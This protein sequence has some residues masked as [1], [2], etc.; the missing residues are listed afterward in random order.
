MEGKGMK[1]SNFDKKFLALF[2]LL[3]CLIAIPGNALAGKPGFDDKE[4]RIGTFGPQTGVAAS[5]GACSRAP[6]ILFSMVNE[7]GGIHGRKIKFYVRDDQYNPALAKT[8]VKELVEKIGVLAMTAMPCGAC[9]N[10]VKAYMAEHQVLMCSA[11]TSAPSPVNEDN[12]KAG[13]KINRYIFSFPPIF[14]DEASILTEYIVNKLKIKKIGVLYQN[15]Q[16]GKGGY[17]GV[18]QRMNHLGLKLTEAIPIEPTEKDLASQIL[19]LKN[20]GAEGVVLWMNTTSAIL[21]VKTAHATNYKPQFFSF[22]GTADYPLMMKLSGGL[23]EGVINS[24]MYPDLFSDDPTIKA[25]RE[26][27]KKYAPEEEWGISLLAGFIN[28]EPL[29][30]GLKRAGRD[31]SPEALIKALETLNNWKGTGAPVTY[32]KDYHQGT[33]AVRIVKCGPGGKTILLQDWTPNELATWKKK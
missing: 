2:V 9:S 14:E 28:T 26:A 16:F 29:V 1:S 18:K 31:L 33:D 7:Q 17:D 23:W 24:T 27:T 15:D 19:R 20:S 6:G 13:D 25:Y 10:A 32:T 11:A 3:I 8:A 22:Y 12:K 4:I 30:E 5:W 21:S